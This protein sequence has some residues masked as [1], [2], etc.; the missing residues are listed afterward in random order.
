MK[1]TVCE[2]PDDPAEF[3]AQWSGLVRHVRDAGS[4]LVLLP[5]MPFC[6]WFAGSPRFDADVW[7]AAVDSHNGWEQRMS[8]FSPAFVLGTRPV[9]F[10]N[11]R[12]DEAFV[13]DAEHGLRSVHA[14]SHL[15]DHE[16]AREGS[17]YHS[18]TPEFV[19][20]E[21]EDARIGF[22]VGEE[23]WDED[24]VRRYGDGQI[25]L[26]ATPR[27]G[28]RSLDGWLDEWLEHGRQ[29][30]MVVGAH[31]LS[32][33]RSGAF[34][35]QGWIIAPDGKVLGLTSPSYPFLSLDLELVPQTHGARVSADSARPFQ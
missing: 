7:A 5:D 30:A 25:D 11:A 13:W 33:N 34:G 9:D 8:E 14:K 1:V 27:A 26:L 35:G 18:A 31:S 2:L 12:Y 15:P 16:G 20:L 32:S 28:Q 6:R 24:A 29:A 4:E 3:Q 17:W 19:P 22:L 21:L 10:G 23:L